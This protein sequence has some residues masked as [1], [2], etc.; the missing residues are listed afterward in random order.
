M[1]IS[2]RLLGQ[3]NPSSSYDEKVQPIYSLVGVV[4]EKSVTRIL[5]MV[6]LPKATK[7]DG[8]V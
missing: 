4:P 3:H 8:I 5:G 6:W 2:S 1:T 7:Q